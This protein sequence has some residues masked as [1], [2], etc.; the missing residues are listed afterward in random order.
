MSAFSECLKRFKERRKLTCAKMADVC[1]M[2]HTVLFRWLNGQNVP[3]DWVNV[4][5]LI[6]KLHLS[7]S[8]SME[9]RLTYERTTLGEDCYQSYHKI[10]DLFEV[11]H[12][13]VKESMKSP[14]AYFETR[15]IKKL[16]EFLV[17]ENKMDIL[18]G[19]RNV[20]MLLSV[21]KKQNI[22]MK[23][24][25]IP[26]EFVTL[27]KLFCDRN[28]T[29]NVE[30]IVYL[31]EEEE[32]TRRYNL[33]VL[34]H[35]MD[36][37]LQKNTV[38]FY[39]AKEL[40]VEKKFAENI[41]LSDTFM[42]KFDY[43]MSYG[44]MTFD[45]EWIHFFKESYEKQKAICQPVCRRSVHGMEVENVDFYKEKPYIC[46]IE[47]MPHLDMVND[48]NSAQLD[49]IFFVEGLELFME[50][51]CLRQSFPATTRP[52][53]RKMRYLMLEE[54]IASFKKRKVAFHL[55]KPDRIAWLDCMGLEYVRGVDDSLS[56]KIVVENAQIIRYEIINEVIKKQFEGFFEYFLRSNYVYTETET[57]E[58][59]EKC[60]EKY[61]KIWEKEKKTGNRQV[62]KK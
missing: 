39:C 49:S 9:L 44:I 2:D 3:K 14:V 29:C 30:G 36:M 12:N 25:S 15:Q 23:L 61:K 53:D 32:D 59:L 57:L 37:I 35:V 62:R 60:L 51:G 10:I 28:S 38:Q 47:Y 34:E 33:E 43:Q 20:F 24:Q 54:A 16:P 46:K 22:Y 5:K 27:M 4:E 6:A 26:Q 13:R 56:F 50:H 11:I 55:V 41:L 48:K 1:D 19:I 8:E 21:Q 42:I 31:R 45:K 18:Q 52:L 58:Y 17:L 40:D 7:S